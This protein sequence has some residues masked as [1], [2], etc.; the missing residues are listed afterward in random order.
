MSLPRVQWADPALRVVAQDLLRVPRA[1]AKDPRFKA[2]LD[3]ASETLGVPRSVY[4]LACL[5]HHLPLRPELPVVTYPAQLGREFL[6]RRL[7]YSISEL[8]RAHRL[9][10]GE[11]RWLERTPQ[12]A[13]CEAIWK[14]RQGHEH[15]F[16]DVYAVSAPTPHLFEELRAAWEAWD[17]LEAKARRSSRRRPRRALRL[18]E[19]LGRKLRHALR[20]AGRRLSRPKR[21]DT[22]KAVEEPS[23]RVTSYGHRGPK[24]VGNLPALG[25]LYPALLRGPLPRRAR[26]LGGGGAS[27]TAA[28]PVQTAFS[29]THGRAAADVEAELQ[30]RWE[31]RAFTLPEAYPTWWN[32][33]RRAQRPLEQA[34]DRP[35][36]RAL[37]RRLELELGELDR[38]RRR[39]DALERDVGAARGELIRRAG[40]AQDEGELKACLVQAAALSGP[41][42][43]SL[44]ALRGA[45]VR[46]L[47]WGELQEAAGEGPTLFDQELARLRTRLLEPTLQF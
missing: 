17:E 13:E 4:A 40:A 16:A 32:G 25:R 37:V 28:L 5:L 10:C 11:L 19:F 3:W 22:P 34:R 41:A 47:T 29:W 36:R 6:A 43:A 35:V 1:F 33:L 18:V 20:S 12:M 26:G 38:R 44:G 23:R 39:L 42:A 46:E 9:M 21:V 7:G 14:D 31:R 24:L 45:F 8:N 30:R 27:D 2:E 15:A